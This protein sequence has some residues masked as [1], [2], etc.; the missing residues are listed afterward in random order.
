MAVIPYLL[1]EYLR[2]AIHGH[3]RWLPLERVV[4]MLAINANK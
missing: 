2:H 3:D 4:P 1:E